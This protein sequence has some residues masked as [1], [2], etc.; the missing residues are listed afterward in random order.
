M[1]L[2]DTVTITTTSV[3]AGTNLPIKGENFVS[4]VGKI[5]WPDLKTVG[6][7]NHRLFKAKLA[8]PVQGLENKFQYIKIA[9]WNSI[10]DALNLISD[11]MFIKI[12]GHI[13][14]R[15]YEGKCK[16]CHGPE[17]KY[18]TEVIVD[19]FIKLEV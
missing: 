5:V 11:D 17:K 19:N 6:D 18:W 8:I 1:M 15:S 16:H 13:E 4:L 2:H 14:E 3:N 9:G 10:A 12:H 7:K